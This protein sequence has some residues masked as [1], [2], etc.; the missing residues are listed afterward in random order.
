MLAGSRAVRIDML[1]R[2]SDLIRAR[3]TWRAT[4][5]EG[6]AIPVGR[7]R[8]RRLPRG[9]RADVGG[10]LLGRGVCLDLDGARLPPFP[11]ET[12]GAKWRHPK[13]RPPT[14]SAPGTASAPRRTCP[15]PDVT[16]DE[17]WR[18]ASAGM[19]ATTARD[20]ATPLKRARTANRRGL[21]VRVRP[22]SGA[23]KERAVASNIRRSPRW[24]SSARASLPAAKTAEPAVEGQRLDKWLWCAR[25]AKTRTLAVA[26]IDA[27]KVRVN[28]D[29]RLKPSR[30]VRA[31]DV[32][33]ARAPAGCSSCACWRPR[34]GEAPR[35]SR[36][37]LYEDL[38][39][40]PPGRGSREGPGTR[41]APDQA[42]SP[43]HR[44]L[45]RRQCLTRHKATPPSRRAPRA[46]ARRA[47]SGPRA[48]TFVA[49]SA[50]TGRLK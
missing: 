19:R 13:R 2:L 31:G 12:C 23:P 26:L 1:E 17:I 38:T 37:T 33:T 40:P 30:L 41:A 20:T 43:P 42:R 9:A 14:P 47:R 29:A 25:L 39:P 6:A 44:R 22:S 3:M 27:G 8:R 24:K 5:E 48:A 28:G 46:P 7:D 49:R 50:V 21:P 16:F 18:P 4:S 45:A 11:A 32:V 15:Q 34:C 36:R 35:Q 10:R